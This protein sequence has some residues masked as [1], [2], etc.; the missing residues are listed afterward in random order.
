MDVK[1]LHQ[2][3]FFRGLDAAE[4]SRL[5]GLFVELSLPAEHRV[6]TEG[7]PDDAFYVI[8]EGAVVIYRDAVG[9]PLQLL[10]RLGEH[11]YFG[12][13]GLFEETEHTSSARTSEP[14]RLLKIG[15]REL[16]RFLDDHPGIAL[17]FQTSAAKRH[18]LNVAATLEMSQTRDERIRVDRK[19]VLTMEDGG[20][21]VVTL[22]N[23]SSGGLGLRDVPEDWQVGQV[24]R[25]RVSFGK[26][27]LSF[28]GRVSWRRE[29]AVGIAFLSKSRNHDAE[30]SRSLRWLLKGKKK[31]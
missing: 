9:K 30:I 10:A 31:A 11:Q 12:E 24:V 6:F 20:S 16:L 26:R 19:V 1:L 14:S 2:I 8:K 22:D 29:N 4:L 28:H 3:E 7:S 5:A 27:S 23:L 13:I 15:K 18:S 21:H 17:R 25:F